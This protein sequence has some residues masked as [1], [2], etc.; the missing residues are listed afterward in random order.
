MKEIIAQINKVFE[1]KTRL[2]VMSALMVNTSIDFTDLRDLLGITDGNLASNIYLLERLKY[3]KVKKRIIARKMRTS[4]SIT[5]SGRRAFLE[6]LK[7]LE[8]LIEG[9]N[10]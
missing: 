7:A 4:Y 1:N 2:G 9:L 3:L 6:H 10:R 5:E 8:S